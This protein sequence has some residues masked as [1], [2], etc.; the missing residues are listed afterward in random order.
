M[1][2]AAMVQIRRQRD[3]TVIALD[4]E[5]GALDQARFQDARDRLLAEAQSAEPPLV[6]IDLSKTSYMGSAFIE[7]LVRVCKRVN[8]RNGRLV[9]CGV[10]PF[11]AEVLV[12]MRL[13]KI[14][15]TFPDVDEAVSELSK[16]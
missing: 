2:A 3:V 5:Y 16:A 8:A 13:D 11:C 14:F 10:Q 15:E 4:A 12:T 1:L 6:A 7:V 9:L